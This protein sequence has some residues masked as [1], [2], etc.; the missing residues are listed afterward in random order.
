MLIFVTSNSFISLLSR[1][2]LIS[3]LV[4]SYL[5]R[6]K[7]KRWLKVACVLSNIFNFLFKSNNIRLLIYSLVRILIPY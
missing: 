1:C 6:I 5:S 7:D 2:S 4:C 3:S